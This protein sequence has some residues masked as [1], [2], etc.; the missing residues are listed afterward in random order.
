MDEAYTDDDDI[1]DD[2]D[3]D[4]DDDNTDDDKDDEAIWL[5]WCYSGTIM[6]LPWSY[7]KA[8]S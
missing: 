6:A 2:T 8:G 4:N 7:G 1:D 3:D 5:C